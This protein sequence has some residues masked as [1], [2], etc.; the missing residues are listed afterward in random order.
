MDESI[1]K[2]WQKLYSIETSFCCFKNSVKQPLSQVVYGT[3]TGITSDANFTRTA[4]STRIA[5]P[6]VS[7]NYTTVIEQNNNV[8]GFGIDG[9]GISY[10]NGTFLSA[11]YIGDGTGSG[12]QSNNAELLT[13]NLGTG[14]VSF[15]Q[16]FYDKNRD[17]YGSTMG[18]VSGGLK[19]V[20]VSNLDG[21]KLQGAD[22][23]LTE[24]PNTRDDSGSDPVKNILYTDGSG[25]LKSAP[26][27]KTGATGGEPT[28][29]Y[30]GEFYFDT[31]LVKM[32]FWNGAVWAI[33]TSTP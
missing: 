13:V 11:L 23:T 29:P 33:I 17:E 22:V 2:L 4:S 12:A 6:N 10:N 28:S 8:L 1:K 7:T 30:L 19:A 21:I 32:K 26:P 3:G 31:T 18:V 14:D 24:Y 5:V 25:N 20:S 27:I 16:A 9:T 15:V